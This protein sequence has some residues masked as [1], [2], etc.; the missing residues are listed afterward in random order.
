MWRGTWSRL[1]SRED[2]RHGR[3]LLGLR[4]RIRDGDEMGLL[5]GERLSGAWGL[6]GIYEDGRIFWIIWDNVWILLG[7]KSYFFGIC[8]FFLIFLL[9]AGRKGIKK[10]C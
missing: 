2:C 4:Y 1:E 5:I 3:T 10:S 9:C 7:F 6:A 8:G